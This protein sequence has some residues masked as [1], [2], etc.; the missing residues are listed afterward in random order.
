LQ[1]I[2]MENNLSETAFFEPVNDDPMRKSTI[3]CAGSLRPRR[4]T[5]A[6]MQPW[7]PPPSFFRDLQPELEQVVFQSMSGMLLV[8]RDGD[9]LELDFPWR[10]PVGKLPITD[11]MVR[12]PGAQPETM[13]LARELHAVFAVAGT[14]CTLPPNIDAIASISPCTMV[15]TASGQTDGLAHVCRCIAPAFGIR[16]PGGFGDGVHPVHA[17][18]VFAERLVEDVLAAGQLSARGGDVRLALAGDRVR[19]AG[20]TV[21]RAGW[22]VH[23]A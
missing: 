22:G 9:L 10:Q 19:I 23:A 17:R 14:V 18:P 2:A 12:A 16:Y 4:S 1:R 20:K 7:R 3:C 15:V 11:E 13:L 21:F 8:R 6:G 5:S